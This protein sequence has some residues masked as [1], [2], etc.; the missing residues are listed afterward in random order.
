MNFSEK[1]KRSIQNKDHPLVDINQTISDNKIQ[2]YEHINLIDKHNDVQMVTKNKQNKHFKYICELCDFKSNKKFNYEKHLKTDKHNDVQMVTKNKQNKQ[3]KQFKYVCE[4]CDFKSNKKFNYEKHL[5]SKK[6]IGY[7]TMIKNKQKTS[8]IHV[9]ICGKEY[10]YKQGLSR[11]K[12][13]CETYKNKSIVQVNENEQTNDI[14]KSG[15]LQNIIQS[16]TTSK[17]KDGEQT[18][19]NINIHTGNNNNTYNTYEQIQTKAEKVN[20]NNNNN[21]FNVMNY[22]N[23][24]CKDAYNLEDYAKN[25]A[26]TFKHLDDL[27]N[28]GCVKAYTDNFISDIKKL[29]HN[30]RPI[31]CT[32]AK[33]KSFQVK[34]KGVW[35]RD[36]GPDNEIIVDSLKTITNN[37]CDTLKQWKNLN[38][39]WLDDERKQEFANKTTRNIVDIYTDTIQKKIINNLT[40]LN[41]NPTKSLSL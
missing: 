1:S 33:R 35:V 28:K 3:N 18:I 21:T 25:Y 40:C 26:V 8:D 15:D 10:S 30:K 4:L 29:P 12:K 14:I 13:T 6:H 17:E 9:C 20:N 24:E 38:K 23:T 2:M 36:V 16:I 5:Q 34:N 39:D 19:I 41:P 11:H 37:Q 32:D 7:I 27:H 22:L 31:H